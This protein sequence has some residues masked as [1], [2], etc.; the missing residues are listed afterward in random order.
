MNELYERNKFVVIQQWII[1]SARL[2]KQKG[3]WTLQYHFWTIYVKRWLG[4]DADEL[5]NYYVK[6]IKRTQNQKVLKAEQPRE[7]F[8][9][10]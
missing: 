7:A 3:V 10:K 4:A 5:Y 1:T 2:Y 8:S 9:D 6:N